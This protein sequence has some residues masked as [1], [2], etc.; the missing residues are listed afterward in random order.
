MAIAIIL[1]QELNYPK[2]FFQNPLEE[3]ERS[4]MSSEIIILYRYS[5]NGQH[6]TITINYK[7]SAIYKNNT[8]IRW[9]FTHQIKHI[10]NSLHCGRSNVLFPEKLECMTSLLLPSIA[11]PSWITKVWGC[12][13]SCI[14]SP[15][16]NV[17]LRKT[18]F[19]L[20]LIR[21]IPF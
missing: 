15:T 14:L 7:A 11:G 13:L 4:A 12:I 9:T 1:L 18:D 10:I 5:T 21:F 3:P 2:R 8:K 19:I 6:Y 20:L 17:Y 16:F